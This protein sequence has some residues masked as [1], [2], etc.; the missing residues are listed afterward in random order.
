MGNILEIKNIFCSYGKEDVLKDVS[1]SVEEGEIVGIIGPNGCGKTTLFRAITKIIPVRYGYIFYKARDIK[2][3]SIKDMSKEIAVVFQIWDTA[4]S[5]TVWE[6]ILMG[7]Y[8]HKKKFEM[9]NKDDFSICE[10]IMSL[11]DIVHLRK[12][13]INELSGGERQKVQIAQ[14]LCQEPQFLLLDEPTSHLDIG[15][16]IEICN[17]LQGLN[18]EGKITIMVIFHDLNLA[19]EY[20]D[21]LILLKD[22][23]VHKIGTPNEVL[24]YQNIEE[25]YKTIVL[26][27]ENPLSKRPY[28]FLVTGYKK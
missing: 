12:R 26:V 1:F 13:F 27:K 22:G 10:R 28:V 19:S 7:R 21:K 23:S 6:Y 18:K 2:N 15:H 14:A 24:T 5:Y 9:L 8:P 25:V 20:C 11:T 4:F 3:I 16:Q 17:L